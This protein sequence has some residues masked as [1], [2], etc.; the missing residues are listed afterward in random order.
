[1]HCMFIAYKKVKSMPIAQ[2]I[3]RSNWDYIV[4]APYSTNEIVYH[5]KMLLVIYAY[6]EPYLN[7]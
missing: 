3:G 5:L 1:M 6:D 4:E 7:H 2:R